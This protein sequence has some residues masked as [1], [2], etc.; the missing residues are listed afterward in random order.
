MVKQSEGSTISVVVPV[1][2]TERY[3]ERCLNS[4]LDQSYKHIEIIVVNDGSP[5]EVSEIMK[6]YENNSRILFINNK[7]NRGLLRARVC[8][9]N[10][11]KGEYIAFVDSDDYVSFDFYRSLVVRAEETDADITIGK[12]VWEDHGNRHIYNHHESAMAFEIL[13]GEQIKQSFFSQE[14]QCYSWHT[15]WNKLY[16]KSLWDRCAKEFNDVTEHIIMTEDIFFSSL[17]FFHAQVVARVNHDAYF[18]CVNE[19]ASTNSSGIKLDRYLKNVKDIR[20]VFSRVEAYLRKQNADPFILEGIDRGRSHYARM[21]KNL[22]LHSFV[23][24]ELSSALD[25][26]NGLS[27]CGE[28]ASE[29]CFFESIRTPWNGGLEYIKEQIRESKAEYISFDIFDTLVK[30]PFYEPKDILKLLDE[31]FSRL[32]NNGISFSKIRIEAENLARSFYGDRMAVEDVTLD[33]IYEFIELHYGISCI[34]AQ[35]MKTL[36]CD[37]EVRFCQ[38]RTAGKE[39]LQLAVALGKHVILI[40][41]M[42][43]KS[44]VIK[45]ILDKCGID[46]YEKLYVSCEE[47]CLKY[48][49]HLFA[50]VLVDLGKKSDDFIHL[51]DSWKSDVEGSSKA[52]IRSI[53]FPKAV[54]VFE[55]KINGCVT[56]RCS[57]IGEDSCGENINYAK[58]IE[59][60]GTRCMRAMVANY[61]FDNP[62]R[63]FNVDSDFNADASFMGFYLLGMHMMGISKWLEENIQETPY[64]EILFLARDGF[65]PMKAFETYMQG[66]GKHASC[67]YVQASRKALMPF[68]VKEELNLYQM[69]IEYQA[70]TPKTLAS[71]LEFL[72]TTDEDFWNDLSS[73]G[74]KQNQPFKTLEEYHKFIGVYRKKAYDPEK[75]KKAKQ[76]VKEYY[77]VIPNQSIAFDM[78][79]SGRIQTAICEASGKSV[80]VMFLHEDYLSSTRIKQ[81]A[82]YEIRDF[83]DYYP[84]ITGLMRE[85]IFSDTQ[86]SCI[87]FEKIGEKIVPVFEESRHSLADKTIVALLQQGA[88]RFVKEYMGLFSE[89]GEALDYSTKVVSLPFEGFLRKTSAFDMHIFSAS[90]FEDMVFGAKERINI[91]TFAMDGLA[92]MGWKPKTRA[93]KAEECKE[94]E[95]LEQSEMENSRILELINTS[96]QIKRAFVWLILDWKFFKEKLAVNIQRVLKK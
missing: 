9:A 43:L 35:K 18:Y 26:V 20:Y 87:G 95:L 30:R 88:V 49:G 27:D 15:I 23:D 3:L 94:R 45:S 71:L 61:Y 78:G 8:G 62:Y 76:L 92:M 12:T 36:E 63:T 84:A 80:D 54:E 67:S 7:E 37:N 40:T 48:N 29:E 47:R 83:Y 32:T 16:K 77:S 57:N 91:E 38:P 33:E 68:M 2:G 85:H 24:D 56:N 50:R 44:S 39:L 10:I 82:E 81:Y 14:Y 74:L 90:Y 86:G 11:A 5:G 25:E 53:F 19:T 64:E 31:P 79:Y 21:W 4:L 75:H 96:S 28:S 42:Y 89:F 93:E 46:G 72:G 69:P 70:H 59:N 73:K 1:Y 55:N 65:L 6:N 22:A 60:L 58:S 17:L 41:D 52:N 51:G 66:K 13:E 34:T